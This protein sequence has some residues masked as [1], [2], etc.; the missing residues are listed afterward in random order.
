MKKILFILG[1]TFISV[2]AFSQKAENNVKNVENY[3]KR[4]I[5]RLNTGTIWVLDTIYGYTG[6][7]GND[8]D[9][10]QTE[11]TKSRN[12]HGLPLLIELAG[13]L[14]GTEQ[15]VNIY[16][17]TFS[18]FDNDTVFEF[19]VKEWNTQTNAWNTDLSYYDKKSEDGKLLEHF[20]RNWDNDEQYFYAGNKDVY[21]YDGNLISTKKSYDWNNSDWEDFSIDYYYYDSNGNDTLILQKRYIG[22]DNLRDNW[23][24]RKTY[25]SENQLVTELEQ[26]YDSYW[27]EWINYSKTE[28][29][30]QDDG[31][32]K[33]QYT[34][35]YDTDA[36]D[37]YDL[38]RTTYYYNSDGLLDYKEEM[39]LQNIN[40]SLK[41]EYTYNSHL[42][43]TS[44]FLY[45]YNSKNW[46]LFYK[47]YDT[48]D[49]NYN[50]TSFY[51]Q[52]LDGTWKNLLKEEYFWHTFTNIN[53]PANS[54]VKI[55]PNPATDYLTIDAD[56]IISVK[57]YNNSGQLVL[58]SDSKIVDISSI[59]QGTYN[60]VI[61]TEKGNF[62][63]IFVKK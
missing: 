30:Y 8:W 27:D 5:N 43:E 47:A 21:T 33:S 48:Y 34:Q 52:T 31:K 6:L 61:S 25:N 18:Y 14:E 7:G 56:K 10:D 29:S 16:Q 26:M 24:T 57:I 40:N 53:T 11:I 41:Y 55:F 59:A 38:S 17:S 4:V 39:D 54:Y 19:K 63:T 3:A 44:F 51:S 28:Y 35:R 20:T 50:Q 23:R 42:D 15:W 46:T 36:S 9:F 60:A 22:T 37:W 45:S 2:L 58:S 1:L 62:R 12:S 49:E 32:L 13:E